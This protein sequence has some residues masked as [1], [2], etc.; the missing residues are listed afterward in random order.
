MERMRE[1][2]R[3]HG[4]INNRKVTIHEGMILDGYQMYL[5]CVAEDVK[6]EVQAEARHHRWMRHLAR[7]H[8]EKLADDV[9]A[10]PVVTMTVASAPRRAPDIETTASISPPRPDFPA[11]P[12]N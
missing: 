7:R 3:K 2:I 11:T 8:H 10:P 9:G 4:V 5:A 12:G 1:G 6:P